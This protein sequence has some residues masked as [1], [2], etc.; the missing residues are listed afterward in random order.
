MTASIIG[1]TYSPW[2]EINIT[3]YWRFYLKV[4]NLANVMLQGSNMSCLEYDFIWV[5]VLGWGT[6]G[7]LPVPVLREFWFDQNQRAM[8]SD[9]FGVLPWQFLIHFIEIWGLVAMGD[10]RHDVLGGYPKAH[11][12]IYKYIHTICKYIYIYIYI[13]I[14][15]YIYICTQ[16]VHK[17]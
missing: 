8:M 4:W 6:T 11:V 9:G 15:I 3:R 16:C 14:W 12:A 2:A 10:S 13:Y 17:M 5:L 7:A 1:T